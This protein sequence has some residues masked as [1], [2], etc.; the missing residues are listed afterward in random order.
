MYTKRHLNIENG[1]GVL[2]TSI[3]EE[4]IT[5]YIREL[6]PERTPF[7]S[8]LE[9][10]AKE[11]KVPIIEPE[12]AQ[13]LRFLLKLHRPKEILEVGTAIGYSAITM[14]ETLKDNFQ[15]TSLEKDPDMIE[16]AI[17]NIEKAGFKDQ[18][19]IIE[20]DALETF[21][22]LSKHYDFIFLDAAKGQYIE[23]MNYSL[24]LLEPGGIIVSDNVLYKGMVAQKSEV[25]RR[26]RTLV[27]RL[28]GYLEL[29]NH[30][31]G[32]TSSVIPIGDGLALTYKE[33]ID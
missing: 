7:L 19:K 26:Q 24:K 3:N 32:V 4:Y 2:M 17:L 6:L 1:K 29:I 28:R 22:H 14:A 12:I 21:P 30:I 5:E 8:E 10:Y 15:I 16:E 11:N 25:K 18:I 31:E 13:F 9:N 33:L 27:T 23:F 20:G